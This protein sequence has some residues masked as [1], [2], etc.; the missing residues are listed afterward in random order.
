[1]ADAPKWRLLLPEHGEIIVGVIL[2]RAD[3][4]AYQPVVQGLHGLTVQTGLGLAFQIPHHFDV[5]GQQ[6]GVFAA[7]GAQLRVIDGAHQGLFVLEMLAGLKSE[8]M[9]LRSLTAASISRGMH[10][11]VPGAEGNIVALYFGELTRRV[12]AAAFD[13]LGPHSLERAGYNYPAHFL[14]CFKWAIGGGT[15][16]IRRNTIGERVLGLPKGPK[17]I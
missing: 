3:H 1:M 10:E 2:V 15:S 16:E 7:V 6:E 8:V 9:A 5:L 13:L 4:V 12:N 11:T 17:A 14:E